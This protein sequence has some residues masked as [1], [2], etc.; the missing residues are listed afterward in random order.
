RLLAAA[1]KTTRTLLLAESTATVR[2]VHLPAFWALHWRELPV[3]RTFRSPPPS[4][5][6]TRSIVPG[7]GA[8]WAVGPQNQNPPTSASAE[9]SPTA[10]RRRPNREDRDR[11]MSALTS[12]GNT[13]NTDPKIGQKFPNVD[14]DLPRRP[15]RSPRHPGPPR[16]AGSRRRRQSGRRRSRPTAAGRRRAP[17]SDLLAGQLLHVDVLE[18]HHVDVGDEPGGAVHVPHPR[19]VEVDVEVDPAALVPDLHLHVVGEVETALGLD[20]VGEHGQDVAILLVELEFDLGFVPLEVF[21]A[22]RRLPFLV[23]V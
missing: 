1:A 21:R 6:L 13:G 4:G 23:R 19:V 18:R 5:M 22:H 7:A 16:P 2:L 3:G 20:D 11:V 14:A 8:P 12:L 9:T 10:R 15:P 17:P